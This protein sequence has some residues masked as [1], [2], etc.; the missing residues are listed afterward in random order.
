MADER[1]DGAGAQAAGDAPV[2][3]ARPARQPAGDAAAEVSSRGIGDWFKKDDEDEAEDAARED[4]PGWLERLYQTLAEL[5]SDVSSV[6]VRTYAAEDVGAAVQSPEG[7]RPSIGEVGE[8]R[9]WTHIRI[10]GDTDVCVP[11]RDGKV[12]RALWE[13][14]Q[15]VVAQAQAQ[16]TAML[17]TLVGALSSYWTPKKK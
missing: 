15:G 12:D 8:L 14:H 1:E 10:D 11:L 17:Q 9:A 2:P 16:R 7:E 4:G 5:A 13:L 3:A 6:T